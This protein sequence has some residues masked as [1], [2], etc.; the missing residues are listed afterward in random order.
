MTSSSNTCA[1]GKSASTA[2]NAGA[3]AGVPGASHSFFDSYRR[4][5]IKRYSQFSFKNLFRTMQIPTILQ[6]CSPG[7]ESNLR[8]EI[9]HNE[10]IARFGRYP[11][12]NAALGRTSTPEEVTFLNQPRSSF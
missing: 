3:L 7:P 6:F 12:R 4:F 10:I 2:N 8:F 1:T 5:T 9:A 11:H